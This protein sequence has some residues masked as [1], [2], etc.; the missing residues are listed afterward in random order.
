MFKSDVY[1]GFNYFLG[2]LQIIFKVSSNVFLIL[3]TV[4]WL[5]LCGCLAV[6]PNQIRRRSL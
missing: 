6:F 3:L 4:F 1:V 2:L 5:V